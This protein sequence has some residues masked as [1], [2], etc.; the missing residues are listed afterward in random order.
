ML[1][2]TGCLYTKGDSTLHCHQDVSSLA[3]KMDDVEPLLARVESLDPRYSE[4]GIHQYHSIDD[5]FKLIIPEGAIVGDHQIQV[6][7][8]KFGAFGPFEYPDRYKPISP[9]VWFCSSQKKFQRPLEIV[10]PYCSGSKNESE[11]QTHLTFLKAD[12]NYKRNVS[13]QKVFQFKRVDTQPSFN[14]N[15]LYGSLHTNHFCFYCVGE[16]IRQDTDQA[17]FCLIVAKPHITTSKFTIS[18]CLALDLPTCQKVNKQQL[19]NNM[20]CLTSWWLSL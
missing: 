13:G 18:I 9:I 15:G 16:Y 10:L 11:D 12:H 4:N 7:V 5:D 1:P 20:Y 14:Q 19:E 2:F 8:I 17:N 3:H 6:A